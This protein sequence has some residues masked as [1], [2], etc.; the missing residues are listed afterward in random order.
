MIEMAGGYLGCGDVGRVRHLEIISS[1]RDHE[2]VMSASEDRTETEVGRDDGAEEERKLNGSSPALTPALPCLRLCGPTAAAT[3]ATSM[4]EEGLDP[5]ATACS[6]LH[7]SATPSA[8]SGTPVTDSPTHARHHLR[9]HLPFHPII[10]CS[11]F[12][13]LHRRPLPKLTYCCLIAAF[14][15]TN[16]GVR[17]FSLSSCDHWFRNSK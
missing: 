1:R 12:T 3:A 4:R 10:L 14:I 2:N 15:H 17:I 6:D 8:L 5:K 13:L 9:L 16:T 11:L 7:F